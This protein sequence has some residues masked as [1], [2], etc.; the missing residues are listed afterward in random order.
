MTLFVA[1][2][3]SCGR[4]RGRRHETSRCVL[5]ALR[6]GLA[7]AE[8]KADG[9]RSAAALEDNLWTGSRAWKG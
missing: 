8:N 6:E 3:M 5:P 7:H 1:G 2:Q 9:R 4:M